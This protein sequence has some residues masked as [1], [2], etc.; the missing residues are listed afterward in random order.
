MRTIRFALVLAAL[1][2]LMPGGAQAVT[3]I[4]F[5]G[6]SAN[7][8]PSVLVDGYVFASN[9]YG[10]FI[11]SGGPSGHYLGDGNSLNATLSMRAADGGLFD[12]LQLQ[13]GHWNGPAPPGQTMTFIGTHA[14]GST[15]SQTLYSTS[16]NYTLNLTNFTDLVSMRWSENG[17]ASGY[18]WTA[19]YDVTVQAVPVPEPSLALLI[20]AALAGARMV[21][22]FAR[23]FPR[24]GRAP[25]TGFE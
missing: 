8:V 9:G 10:V 25:R 11:Q 15:V 7:G 13:A 1:I 23:V 21:G 5:S 24:P 16:A 14:D 4:D 2:L 20:V 22:C 18:S 17:H 3:F 19:L 12:V 6:A